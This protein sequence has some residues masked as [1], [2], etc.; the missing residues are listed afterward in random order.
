MYLYRN[1]SSFINPFF[2]P[3]PDGIIPNISILMR[4]VGLWS[5]YFLRWSSLTSRP[6]ATLNQLDDLKRLEK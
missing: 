2:Q 6:I 5:D 4:S 1:R 3:Q